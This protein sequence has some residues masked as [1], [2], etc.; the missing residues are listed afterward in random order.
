MGMA[1]ILFNGAEQHE[2]IANIPLTEGNMWNLVKNGQA[3]S[4]KKTFK[5]FMI[6]YLCIAKDKGR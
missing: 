6:L 2:Q 3:V 5:G 4:E 1:T